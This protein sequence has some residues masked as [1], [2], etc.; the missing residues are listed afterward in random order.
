MFIQ[1]LA[2]FKSLYAL[3]IIALRSTDRIP[4]LQQESLNFG[5]DSLTHCPNMKIRYIALI[6][7][8]VTYEAN[9]EFRKHLKTVT[10][11]HKNAKGK[12]K[13]P[14]LSVPPSLDDSS[15]EELDDHFGEL[16]AREKKL[17][18]FSDVRD[19]KIFS[20]R[21]RLGKL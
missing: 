19:V 2:G 21:V 7:Y 5:I 17:T 1:L 4:V 18:K 8:I 13:A 20:Q 3:H 10:E 11:R 14:A 6:I 16:T 12:G 15:C 9:P